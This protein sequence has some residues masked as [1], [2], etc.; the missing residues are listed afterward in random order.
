M[1]VVY[2]VGNGLYLNITNQ[3]PCRCEFC[4]RGR[5]DAVGS[6]DSLW[7]QKEPELAEILRE[8]DGSNVAAYDEVVF[9]GYGEPL[10][11]LD[12]VLAICDHIK[13]KWNIPI[14]I[15]T[16]GLADLIHNKPT[17]DLLAGRID[18]ISISLNAPDSGRYMELCH[19]VFKEKAYPAILAFAAAAKDKI[20][21]VAMSVVDSISKDE[22]EAC[23]K[24]AKEI[25]VDFRVR[26]CY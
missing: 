24:I 19:P 3:C 14:R 8:I 23:R 7:L 5:A 13:S 2:T 6:A 4:I 21:N 20:P 12:E 9:C 11:R 17:L 1:S 10:S 25:G 22:I 15:N 18:G 16:N 26:A